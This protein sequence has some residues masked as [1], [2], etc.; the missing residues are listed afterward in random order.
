MLDKFHY[1]PDAPYRNAPGDQMT[2]RDKID[3]RLNKLEAQLKD[4]EHLNRL[5]VQM[6]SFKPSHRSPSS[7]LSCRVQIVIS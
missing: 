5:T 7:R 4:G 1:H 6:Q 2:I 3:D